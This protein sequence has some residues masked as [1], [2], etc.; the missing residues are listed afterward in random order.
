MLQLHLTQRIEAAQAALTK[1]NPLLNMIEALDNANRTID[2][3]LSKIS[4]GTTGNQF[5]EYASTIHSHL[6]AISN[7]TRGHSPRIVF[8]EV[9]TLQKQLAKSLVE[10]VSDPKEIALIQIELDD[11]AETYDAYVTHQTGVNALPLLLISRRLNHS[12]KSLNS[13]LEYIRNNTIDIKLPSPNESEF[14]LVLYQ[15]IDLKNFTEKLDSLGDLYS[16]LCYV[17]EIS[18]AD[19]PLRI[20]KIESGSLLTRL[21][22]DTKVVDLMLSFL[23]DS[24]KFMHRNFTTEGKIAAIPK[25]IES[26]DAIL[27]FSNRLKENGVDVSALNDK[28]AKSAVSITNSLN[29]LV[30]DQAKVEI[31]GHVH[32]I[33]KDL[34]AALLEYSSKPKLEYKPSESATLSLNPPNDPKSVV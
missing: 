2:T 34:E 21:L 22:G 19:H 1:A 9:E 30:S 31:N 32:S 28:L 3:S 6:A 7:I 16:E 18:E 25:K 8:R 27:N 24:V 10:G 11:F 13:F 4:A 15:V 12:L 26:L 14:S 23:E 17:L 29:I 20:A 5:T 33:S